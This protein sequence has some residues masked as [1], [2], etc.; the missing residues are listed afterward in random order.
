MGH[1][2]P[3]NESRSIEVNG[4]KA[5][6]IREV[7]KPVDAFFIWDPGEDLQSPGTPWIPSIVI[8]EWLDVQ[9]SYRFGEWPWT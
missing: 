1:G 3:V 9:E 2:Q 5:W 7:L 6:Q 4:V 8:V